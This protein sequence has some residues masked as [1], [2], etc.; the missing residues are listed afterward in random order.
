M[1]D[2]KDPFAEAQRRQAALWIELSAAPLV[3]V[4]G[5]VTPSGGGGAKSRGDIDWTFS[6]TLDPWRRVGEQ[7]QLEPLRVQRQVTDS[8]LAVLR[9]SIQPYAVLNV[10]ARV[11]VNS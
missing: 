11:G 3:H 1:T 10:R 7:I 4:S 5:V 9:E 6:F 2:L 8:A